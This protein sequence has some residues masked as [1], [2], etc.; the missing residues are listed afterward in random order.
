M[1]PLRVVYTPDSPSRCSS[2]KL[3]TGTVGPNEHPLDPWDKWFWQELAIWNAKCQCYIHKQVVI[4]NLTNRFQ[5]EITTLIC[6]AALIRVRWIK[7]LTLQHFITRFTQGDEYVSRSDTQ[8]N[9]HYHAIPSHS[10]WFV[11]CNQLRNWKQVSQT[12]NENVCSGFS[13]ASELQTVQLYQY[14]FWYCWSGGLPSAPRSSD[15]RGFG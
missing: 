13:V 7:W 2:G 14:V 4:N 15:P 3:N 10:Y 6:H 5:I 9:Q 8:A 12:L 1:H 11:N